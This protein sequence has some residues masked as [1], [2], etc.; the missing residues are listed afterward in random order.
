MANSIADMAKSVDWSK[1]LTNQDAKNAL[2]GSALGGLLLGGASLMQ[3]RDPEESRLAPVGDAL[4][5]AV[6]GGVAGYGIPKGLSLFADSGRLAPDSDQLSSGFGSWAKPVAGLAGIGAAAGAGRNLVA[7][8][9]GLLR[10]KWRLN[11]GA[12]DVRVPTHQGYAEAYPKAQEEYQRARAAAQG[13]GAAEAAKL[14]DARRNF[15]DAR[16]REVAWRGKGE[17]AGYNAEVARLKAMLGRGSVRA[18][19]GISAELKRRLA[20][21]RDERYIALNGH[22]R[23][24]RMNLGKNLRTMLSGNGEV[25]LGGLSDLMREMS[26]EPEFI[27]ANKGATGIFEKLMNHFKGTN[28]SIYR[29]KN[30]KGGVL[31]PGMRLL[32]RTAGHGIAGALAGGALGLGLRSLLGPSAKDNFAN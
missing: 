15:T 28:G 26:H 29:Q 5:G 11:E 6:L 1:M 17:S 4:M 25:N 20:L 24:S 22:R 12:D 2:I 16:L 30:W 31:T 7:A 14:N 18:N 27:P 9:P 19:K 23:L 32:R 21:L 13:G 3:K 8:V 10:A